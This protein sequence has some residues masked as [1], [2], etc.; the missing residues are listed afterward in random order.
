MQNATPED[1]L[2]DNDE[3][4]DRGNGY[5]IANPRGGGRGGPLVP[6]S[7]RELTRPRAARSNRRGTFG[8]NRSFVSFAIFPLSR[9]AV[10]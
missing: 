4:S 9:T 5:P 3:R 7:R 2:A 8:G 6:R 1:R 10:P